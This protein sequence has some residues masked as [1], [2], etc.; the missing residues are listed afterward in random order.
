MEGD[1]KR[2]RSWR[3]FRKEKIINGGV[4]REKKKN[5]ENEKR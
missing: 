4:D 1:I 2:M 5:K 3:K